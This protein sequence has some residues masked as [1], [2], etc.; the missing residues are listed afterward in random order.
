MREKSIQRKVRPTHPGAILRNM[1]EELAVDRSDSF[2]SLTQKE[3]ARRLGVS[4][5]MVN[6]LINERRNVTADTAIRLSR[7]LKTTPDI[8][9]NLQKAV[10]L[11]DAAKS[12]KNDYAKLRPIAA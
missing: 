1:L 8:W 9:M 11:W 6:D 7:V 10:D 4:R 2:S 5:R 12:N 3:L